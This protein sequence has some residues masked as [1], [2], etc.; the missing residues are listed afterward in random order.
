MDVELLKKSLRES[1][2]MQRGEYRYFINQLTDSIPPIE[3]ALVDEV[4]KASIECADLDIDYIVT[5]E[6]MGIHIA[7]VMGHLTD[8]PY[9]IIRKR[10]YGLDGETRIIQ[11]TGY[12]GSDMYLNGVKE[13][14]IVMIVD[15]V[16]S[17]GNT[18]VAVINA[19]RSRGAIVKDIVCAIG[20]GDGIRNVMTETGYEVKTL[21]CID[22]GDVVK[23]I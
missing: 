21:A 2:V 8:I 11:K 19:L 3:P 17:T 4:A 1:L 22:I 10:E 14:D 7:A 16:I 23:V 5:M 15:A 13:G 20:R 6:A 18:M 12:G 9:N